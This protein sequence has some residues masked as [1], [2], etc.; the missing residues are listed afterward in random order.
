LDDFKRDWYSR[1]LSSMEEPS[2]SCGASPVSEI[3]RFIWLRSFHKPVA[4]RISRVGDQLTLQAVVTTGAGG[5]DPGQ[6]ERRVNKRLSV[7]QWK[8]AISAIDG[9]HFWQMSEVNNHGVVGADGAEWII[10]GASQGR[11]HLVD[12]WSG[13]D[14]VEV[15]GLKFLR[16]AGLE[17]GVGPI[18]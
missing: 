18:Y 14:G 10:E 15:V 5:Y 17:D 11:Y 8:E 2:L 4:V 3:Y 9:I 13:Y 16:L 12:R 1:A 7:D 6:V